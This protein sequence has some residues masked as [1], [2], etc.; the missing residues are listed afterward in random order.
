[1]LNTEYEKEKLNNWLNGVSA[2]PM[3]LDDLAQ[4][5]VNGMPDCEDCTLH[6]QYLGGEG[7]S[8]VRSIFPHPEHYHLYLKLRA[9]AVEMTAI[10]VLGEMYDK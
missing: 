4:L 7:C 3:S 1:M 6:Q 10:A 5:V 8:C 9:M 2:T